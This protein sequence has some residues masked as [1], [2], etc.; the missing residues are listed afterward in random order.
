MARFPVNSVYSVLR[1]FDHFLIFVYIGQCR[2]T[3]YND[4]VSGTREKVGGDDTL[5]P[6]LQRRTVEVTPTNPDS[7]IACTM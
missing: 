1:L 5:Q 7:L 3:K 6:G 4:N 2:A